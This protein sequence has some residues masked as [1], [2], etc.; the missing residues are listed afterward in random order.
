LTLAKGDEKSGLLPFPS[1]T[2][3]SSFGGGGGGYEGFST[4]CNSSISGDLIS[5]SRMVVITGFSIFFGCSS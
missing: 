4:G 2:D 1:S 5:S 3:S